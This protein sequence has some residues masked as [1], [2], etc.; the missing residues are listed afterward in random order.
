MAP[1]KNNKNDKNKKNRKQEQARARENE[2]RAARRARDAA[3]PRVV[4]LDCAVDY[5]K[6]VVNGEVL[7]SIEDAISRSVLLDDGDEAEVSRLCE[8][9]VN[10]HAAL[11]DMSREDMTHAVAN[12]CDEFW[13]KVQVFRPPYTIFISELGGALVGYPMGLT[14]TNNYGKTKSVDAI[15]TCEDGSAVVQLLIYDGKPW[16]EREML[17]ALLY[18]MPYSLMRA[19]ASVRKYAA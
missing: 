1:K 16:T 15:V 3:T 6:V 5:E 14:T 18:E 7:P 8:A 9:N 2:K 12:L 11:L 4:V 17:G 19:A 13:N 10:K